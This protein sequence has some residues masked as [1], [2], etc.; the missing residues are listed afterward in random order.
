MEAEG[1]RTGLADEAR[2]YALGDVGLLRGPEA[3][4]RDLVQ[5]LRLAQAREFA[6]E[7]VDRGGGWRVVVIHQP[8][9]LGAAGQ[10]GLDAFGVAVG[11]A[12]VAAQFEQLDA[13]GRALDEA[14]Q[15][16]GR[17]VADDQHPVDGGETQRALDQLFQIT[18]AVAVGD[19]DN[20]G[21]ALHDILDGG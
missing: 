3:E 9:V 6:V 17:G 20:G 10:R 18:Q 4:H 2:R 5:P 7:D 15:R 21:G 19:R 8:D 14:R 1:A 16:R 11:R 13:P 12:G